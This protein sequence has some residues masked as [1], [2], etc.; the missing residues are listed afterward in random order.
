MNHRI[1]IPLDGTE[2]GE[3]VLPKLEELVLKAVPLPDVE[4]T[5]LRVIPTINFNYLTENDAAQ[6]PYSEDELK[7]L[8]A[9]A[10][11]YLEKVARELSIKGINVKTMV[12]VGHAAQEIIKTAHGID[13]SLIAMSTHGRNGIVR[14]AIGSVTD[15]VIRLE[16]KIPVLAVH[17]SKEKS[18]SP[19]LPIGSLQSLMRH[20]G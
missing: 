17:T 3:S 16:G 13:A 19:V 1:L 5:L 10:L 12:N 14:W 18:E 6:L 4:V 15:T 9:E 11:G 2:V 7:R 8:K 20:A